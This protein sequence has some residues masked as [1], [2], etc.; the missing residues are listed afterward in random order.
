MVDENQITYIVK[1]GTLVNMQGAKILNSEF[2]SL[3]TNTNNDFYLKLVDDVDTLKY[4][5]N[6]EYNT[7]YMIE[8]T[9]EELN[10]RLMNERDDNMKDFCNFYIL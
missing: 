8:M 5:E 2:N 9:Q 7:D 6:D 1:E 3:S 4:E 10:N